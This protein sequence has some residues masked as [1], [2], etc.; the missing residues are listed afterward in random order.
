MRDVESSIRKLV[1]SAILEPNATQGE[2]QKAMGPTHPRV[3]TISQRE[4][5]VR[6]G[7]G[8]REESVRAAASSLIGSWIDCVNISTPKIEEGDEKEKVPQVEE[9]V[10]ALLS[11]F[12]LG[13]GTIAG[14]ALRS[15][16]T[17]RPDIFNKIDLNGT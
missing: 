14:D 17:R 1:L 3:L 2:E 7:L 15:V 13:Q 5:I 10:L 4:Q 16:F 11:L 6:D 12:D 8:D 9:G